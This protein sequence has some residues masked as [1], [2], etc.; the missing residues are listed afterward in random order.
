MKLTVAVYNVEWM[1][2]LFTTDGQP[3]TTGEDGVRSTQLA[4]VVRAVDPD[5]LGVVEGPD[6]TVSGS[7]L[8]SK[9]LEVWAAHHGLGAS[10]KGV[11]GFPSPGQQELCALFKS[12]K[13]T[14]KH[15]PEKSIS[16]HPFNET[17]LVDT[18]DSLVKEQYKHYRP[19]LELSI[20]KAGTTNELARIIVAHTK[21]KGI[22]DMVDM[23][24]FEQL[25][26]RNHLSCS[27]KSTNG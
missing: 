19:P 2:R 23:A 25:S 4:A 18:T 1:K 7:K 8:A 14:L 21:S 13:V 3:K 22:F 15:K 16:K 6:T 20:L 24:R 17:F 27:S 10:Y 5:I 12:D 26:E 9:Q 11:H